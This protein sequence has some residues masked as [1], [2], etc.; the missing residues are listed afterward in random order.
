MECCCNNPRK[1]ARNFFQ[2]VVGI[3][4]IM[5]LTKVA[6]IRISVKFV[7]FTIEILILQNKPCNAPPEKRHIDR[8]A[9]VGIQI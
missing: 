6:K 2:I 8:L 4:I 7:I 5:K 9:N 3:K 1:S